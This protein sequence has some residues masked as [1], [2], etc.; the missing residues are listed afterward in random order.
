VIFACVI[1]IP[2]IGY[3]RFGM[4]SI[5]AFWFAYVITR[6]LGASFADWVGKPHIVHGLGFGSGRVSLILT[7]VI[8]CLVGYLA[9]T[10]ADVR[11]VVPD[12][13]GERRARQPATTE[14]PVR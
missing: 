2:A 7:A 4:N 8:I 9:I 14:D 1:L 10:R 5:L 6:P 3:W 11:R 12:R 13:R